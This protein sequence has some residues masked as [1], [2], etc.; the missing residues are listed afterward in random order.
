LPLEEIYSHFEL[1]PASYYINTNAAEI[2]RHLKVIHRFLTRQLEV[3]EAKDALVPVVD[4]QSFPTQSYSQVS[5]CSWDRLGLFSKICGSFASA[6]LNVLRANI[7]TR[8]D[9]VVLDMFDVCDKQPRRRHGPAGH[10]DG[11]RNARADVERIKENIEFPED[12]RQSAPRRFAAPRFRGSAKCT[13][14]R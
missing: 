5:I 4:W 1:M 7:Y 3:E 11:G 14:P 2:E 8:G 10:P 9:H 12:A 6:E 13:S